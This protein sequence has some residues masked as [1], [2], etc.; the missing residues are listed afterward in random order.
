MSF[1]QEKSRRTEEHNAEYEANPLHQ[2]EFGDIYHGLDGVGILGNARR[3]SRKAN[4][5]GVLLCDARW[6]VELWGVTPDK[7]IRA[8]VSPPDLHL[9]IGLCGSQ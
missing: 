3:R 2:G 5:H 8:S 4:R 7:L 6:S 9:I 1:S